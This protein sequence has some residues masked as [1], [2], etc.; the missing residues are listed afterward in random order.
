MIMRED[1]W[2]HKLPGGL[3]GETG[4]HPIYISLAFLNK[5]NSVDVYAKN[6]LEHPWARFDEFRI[7][8][9][10]QEAMSSIAVSYSGNRYAAEVEL[11]G[12]EGAL[13]VDL[14]SMLVLR[15]GPKTSLGFGKLV[16]TSLSTVFQTLGGLLSNGLKV[17]TG[18][19][20]LGHDNVIEMFVDSVLSN[21]KPPV[22]GE[23][24]REVVRA[25][26]M[27]VDRL[28]TKYGKPSSG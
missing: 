7:E 17:A 1:Y 13:Y 19:F 26:E 20:H 6:F 10:G 27:L 22:T 2:I 12:T 15:Y 18:R 8:L 21:S 4:P 25:M 5:V 23:D 16:S 9:E 3:I 28:Y 24:G 11:F 14:Q